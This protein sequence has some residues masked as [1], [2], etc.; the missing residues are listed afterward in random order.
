M[1][2]VYGLIVL[3][4]AHR[5]VV[6]PPEAQLHAL[7]ADGDVGRGEHSLDLGLVA[8]GHSAVA[9]VVGVVVA[10]RPAGVLS[11]LGL[12]AQW[13]ECAALEAL[14]P[15]E[16][17]YRLVI[18]G[19]EDPHWAVGGIACVV[20]GHYLPSIHRAVV[21]HL[22]GVGGLGTYVLAINQLPLRVAAIGHAHIDAVA[23]GKLCFFPSQN[24][25]LG[26][27]VDGAV[28]RSNQFGGHR[29]AVHAIDAGQEHA[30]DDEAAA[31][32]HAIFLV[33][34]A[35]GV[36]QAHAHVIAAVGSQVDGDVD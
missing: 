20:V 36:D 2:L 35:G 31:I 10:S 18:L 32:V 34:A 24:D 22:D 13:S 14:K 25:V 17:G 26:I 1:V 9:A 15:G 8:V 27:D 30:V 7:L 28:G 12:P 19:G 29:D 23:L 11:T 33:I 6:A 3:S 4:Q 5:A 21:G 16:F